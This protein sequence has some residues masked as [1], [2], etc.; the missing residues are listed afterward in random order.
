MSRIRSHY[1]NLKVARDAPVEVIKSAYRALANK[2]H[3][4]RNPG[5]EQSAKAMKVINVSYDVLIDP[6]KRRAHDAWIDQQLGSQASSQPRQEYR[7][8][9]PPSYRPPPTTPRPT[10]PT[11]L[12]EALGCLFW[13]GM[14]LVAG[15]WLF[16]S[17]GK[18]KPPPPTYSV[19]LSTPTPAPR[20][21]FTPS[22][23][24]QYKGLRVPPKFNEPEVEFPRHGS[25]MHLTRMEA[26]APFA[27]ETQAG[28]NYLL[29][30]TDPQTGRDVA[31]L[32]LVGGQDVEF[33]VPLGTYGVKFATGEKWYGDEHLFGPSTQYAKFDEL[34]EFTSTISREDSLKLSRLRSKLDAANAAVKDF[35]VRNKFNQ[36]WIEYIFNYRDPTTNVI[37]IDRLDSDWWKNQ[38]L[39]KIKNPRVY[40]ALVKRLNARLDIARE[41]Y[42]LLSKGEKIKG[43]SLT[44]FDVE[45]GNVREQSIGSEDFNEPQPESSSQ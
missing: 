19:P 3:P 40:N 28:R 34:M 5:C 22:L 21:S 25:A 8:Q 13:I 11:T 14:L 17:C 38:M 27:V 12:S 29:K 1:D 44:M 36:R 20:P 23:F 4:D 45:G 15:N 26:V 6:D 32:Y 10:E 24:H 41:Y 33:L 7:P 30:L 35:L 16:T 37:G 31:K 9:P 42:G 43:V 39:A 18:S 2:Y